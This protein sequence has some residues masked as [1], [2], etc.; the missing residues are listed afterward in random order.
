MYSWDF[1]RSD[2]AG[3]ATTRNTRGLTRSVM[4]LIVPPLPAASRPSKI[5]TTRRPLCLTQSCSAHNSTCSSRSAFSYSLRFIGLFPSCHRIRPAD[6][7]SRPVAGERLATV[8]LVPLN[9][10]GG[11]ATHGAAQADDQFLGLHD[12]EEHQA[13]A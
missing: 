11:D 5:R 10:R 3:S 7:G 2:G 6:Y 13:A 12:E 8:P 9:S 4:A 1:S